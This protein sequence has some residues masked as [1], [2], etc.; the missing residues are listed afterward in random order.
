MKVNVAAGKD[1]AIEGTLAEIMEIVGQE[2]LSFYVEVERQV[3]QVIVVYATA[4][5]GCVVVAVCQAH[6]VH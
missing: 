6:A 2:V 4:E 3:A 5:V 1:G